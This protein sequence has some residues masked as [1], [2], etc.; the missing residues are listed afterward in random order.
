MKYIKL[1]IVT[2]F[3]FLSFASMASES[4]SKWDWSGIT[5]KK[6]LDSKSE[7]FKNKE[8]VLKGKSPETQTLVNTHE[9]QAIK[10]SP[11]VSNSRDEMTDITDVASTMKDT[12]FTMITVMLLLI[13]PLF[14]FRIVRSNF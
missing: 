1:L 9:A 11:S 3:C 13:V 2:I 7:N 14:L 8:L 4:E 6:S 10:S 5:I 12:L